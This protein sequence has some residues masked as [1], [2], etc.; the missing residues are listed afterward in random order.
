[1][2]YW[3]YLSEEI[4][5]SLAGLICVEKLVKVSLATTVLEKL[6]KVFMSSSCAEISENLV[7]FICLERLLKSCWS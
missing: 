6:V 4:S 3:L 1:M 5:E 2:S 7:G